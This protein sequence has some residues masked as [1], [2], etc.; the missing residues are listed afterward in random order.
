[1]RCEQPA[2]PS[3]SNQYPSSVSLWN[4]DDTGSMFHISLQY[5]PYSILLLLAPVLPH[6][7]HKYTLDYQKRATKQL[8]TLSYKLPYHTHGTKST[9]TTLGS[10]RQVPIPAS[11]IT[12]PHISLSILWHVSY[13]PHTFEK[14]LLSAL[15]VPCSVVQSLIVQSLCRRWIGAFPWAFPGG[16]PSSEW[17]SSNWVRVF[18][19]GYVSGEKSAPQIY[20]SSDY[21]WVKVSYCYQ[22]KYQELKMSD[23]RDLAIQLAV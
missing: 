6:H 17:R 16:A 12:T 15:H 3:L 4:V 9:V 20:S 21:Q 13:R 18:K 23:V 8:S 19:A 1:M 22:A 2:L 14:V 11:L 5:V 10:I 7:T